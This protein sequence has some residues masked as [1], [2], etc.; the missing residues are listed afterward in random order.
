LNLLD[1]CNKAAADKLAR[2]NFVIMEKAYLIRA[3]Q[4]ELERQNPDDNRLEI[5]VKK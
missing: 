3:M 4:L 5:Y 1:P 2:A